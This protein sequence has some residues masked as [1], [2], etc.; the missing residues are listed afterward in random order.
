MATALKKS[1][2]Y[3]W[4]DEEGGGNSEYSDEYEEEESL[5]ENP[6]TEEENSEG[7]VLE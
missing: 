7:E 3:R 2:P 5:E 1:K 4:D 6:F